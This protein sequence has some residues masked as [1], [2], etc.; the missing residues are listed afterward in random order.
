M[1]HRDDYD[2]LTVILAVFVLAFYCHMLG[3]RRE[4]REV[5]NVDARKVK[6]VGTMK[7]SD[8]AA[9]PIPMHVELAFYTDVYPKRSSMVRVKVR[10]VK[11]KAEHS[12]VVGV[13]PVDKPCLV[14]IPYAT[15]SPF[16]VTVS[17]FN[18]T[19]FSD[20]DALIGCNHAADREQLL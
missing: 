4:G 6:N 14:E 1:L 12:T 13:V 9:C 18:E 3:L 19:V 17:K 20:N 11:L 8:A 2:F 16:A 10:A 7:V 5:R 15:I